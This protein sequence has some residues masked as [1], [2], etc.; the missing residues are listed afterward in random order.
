MCQLIGVFGI[1]VR[2]FLNGSNYSGLQCLNKNILRETQ[3]QV[4]HIVRNGQKRCE[5]I[6][7][8]GP[9]EN[10]PSNDFKLNHHVFINL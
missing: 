5:P 9:N 6:D 7:C 10:L 4:Y 2:G 3:I 8:L 1:F